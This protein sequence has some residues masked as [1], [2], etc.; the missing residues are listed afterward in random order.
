MTI[1]HYHLPSISSYRK[2]GVECKWIFQLNGI[3]N[4][5][6]GT[7]TIPL[8]IPIVLHSIP[9]SYHQK[10]CASLCFHY[11]HQSCFMVSADIYKCVKRNSEEILSHQISHV[12]NSIPIYSHQ[13][14]IQWDRISR[15]GNSK[16]G[17]VHTSPIYVHI[18]SI[19]YP[20]TPADA[21]GSA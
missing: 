3:S 21:R 5:D 17:D 4:S 8:D 13:N 14:N 19:I 20:P 11:P 18:S 1:T 16:K 10:Q 6:T 12:F 15:I 7:L 2:G 9:V